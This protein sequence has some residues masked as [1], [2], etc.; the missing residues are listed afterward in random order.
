ML[1]LPAE[2]VG[3]ASICK[4]MAVTIRS[5]PSRYTAEEETGQIQILTF[6]DLQKGAEEP[7][8]FLGFLKG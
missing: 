4:E 3:G 1:K 2:R 7:L 6:P 5:L 8:R